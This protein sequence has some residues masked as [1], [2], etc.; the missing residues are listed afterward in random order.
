[1]ENTYTRYLEIIDEELIE[2]IEKLTKIKEWI[3]VR[4]KEDR[5]WKYQEAYHS[6]NNSIEKLKQNL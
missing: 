3:E 4:F 6:I 2:H 1:M 5:N